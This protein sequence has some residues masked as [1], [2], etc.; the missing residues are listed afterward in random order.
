[1]WHQKEVLII[2]NRKII[3]KYKSDISG[4]FLIKLYGV[5]VRLIKINRLENVFDLKRDGRK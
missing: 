4:Y 1:M 3:Y 2:L 5:F